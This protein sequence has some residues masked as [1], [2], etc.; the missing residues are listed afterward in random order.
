MTPA[1]T[2]TIGGAIASADEETTTKVERP[3]NL[4]CCALSFGAPLAAL[5]YAPKRYS[6]TS[7]IG[8]NPMA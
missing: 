2:Q 3:F 5:A 8:S 6:S 1:M 4:R 7:Q